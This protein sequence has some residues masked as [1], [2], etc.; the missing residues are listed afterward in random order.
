M[1]FDYRTI[2]KKPPIKKFNPS[3][4]DLGQKVRSAGL[5][6]GGCLLLISGINWENLY[7]L[8]EGGTGHTKEMLLTS[9]ECYHTSSSKEPAMGKKNFTLICRACIFEPACKKPGVSL[10]GTPSL[11]RPK[12]QSM[13][14]WLF[15][16]IPYSK[17]PYFQLCKS[18]VISFALIWHL[19]LF[20]FYRW[21]GIFNF[22]MSNQN[23]KYSFSKQPNF[24]PPAV[25]IEDER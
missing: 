2:I 6:A 20:C 18:M 17:K 23:K 16:P 24:Y 22:F 7:P 4:I 8:K 15:G 1:K 12:L 11:S 5:N 14:E 19:G 10:A 9:P 25:T 13:Q 3:R 21:G